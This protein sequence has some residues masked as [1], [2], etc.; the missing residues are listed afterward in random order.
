MQMK[1][2]RGRPPV[3]M[4]LSRNVTRAFVLYVAADHYR[5][6][7]GLSRNIE[8]HLK[9]SQLIDL[10]KSL[11]PCR[12]IFDK[13]VDRNKMLASIKRGREIL[14]IKKGW[15]GPEPQSLLN[16]KKFKI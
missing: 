7:H 10:A 5:K 15:R 4:M 16:R 13:P 14:G 2:D 12:G 6:E 8:L 3:P 1:K 11:Y 9:T